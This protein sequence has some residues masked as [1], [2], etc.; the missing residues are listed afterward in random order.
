L[1]L[2]GCGST[3]DQ[4]KEEPLPVR[5]LR[6]QPTQAASGLAVSGT[7]ARRL[8]TPLGF[9]SAGQIANILVQE[10]ERVRRGQALAA[11]NTTQ[12]DASLAATRAEQVRAD[13]ELARAV[14]LLEKGWVTR[15]RVDNARAAARA[16]AANVRSAQFATATAR[17]V[18][19]ADGLILARLAEPSQVV[20]AGDPVLVLG[21]ASG[22]FVLKVPLNDRHVARVRIGSPALVR[23]ASMDGVTLAGRVVEIGG[24]AAADT[25]SFNAE[26][27][28]P[29]DSRLRSGLIASAVISAPQDS[30]N[31]AIL[32][33]PAAMFAARAGEAFVYVVGEDNK[34]RRRKI[35]IASVS[36]GGTQATGGVAPGEWVAVSGIDRLADGAPVRPARAAP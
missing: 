9:T 29:E 10:G 31:P 36:D 28:L 27:A 11:L 21:E 24:R 23:F 4:A 33:P 26:I 35:R 1:V 25:G 14:T 13:A 3:E 5:V 16:A 19:P 17:I 12:L 32:V 6:V 7:V 18:A 22:G 2:S 34:A 20:G 30:G 15:S 8:E